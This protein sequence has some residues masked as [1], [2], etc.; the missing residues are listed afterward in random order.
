MGS[1]RGLSARDC[2]SRPS[3]ILSSTPQDSSIPLESHC[4]GVSQLPFSETKEPTE[5][6]RTICVDFI[7]G[8]PEIEKHGEI[9]DSILTIIDHCSRFALFIPTSTNWTTEAT[10]DAITHR[11][12]ALF[13][14]PHVVISDR[15]V[16]FRD[17]WAA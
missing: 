13:G 12:V 1:P 10:F 15:D 4:G 5:P 8:L 9:Y 3:W 6:W 16:R 14:W 17:R 11:C 7:T 2:L